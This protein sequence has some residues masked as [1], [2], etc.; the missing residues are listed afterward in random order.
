MAADTDPKNSPDLSR[1]LRFAR[2]ATSIAI[3]A[4]RLLPRILPLAAVLSLFAT[5]SWFGA[6]RAVPD[7]LR[8]GMVAAFAL[9]ALASLWPLRSLR[10]ADRRAIDRRLEQANLLAHAPITTQD[11]RPSGDSDAFAAA[12]WREHQRRMAESVSSVEEAGARTDIPARD[13]YALRAFVALL[14]VTAFAYSF[15]ISGGSLGDAFRAHNAGEVIPARIDA[16]VTPPPYTGLAPI[17][18]TS[19]QNAIKSTVTVP[20]GSLAV[21]RIAGGSGRET[22]TWPQPELPLRMAEGG[23]DASV[24]TASRRFEV[25]LEESGELAISEGTG[26][27]RSWR[28]EVTPDDPPS[29]A[30]QDDPSRAVNGTMTVEYMATDDHR[31]SAARGIIALADDQPDAAHPLYEAPELPLSLPR[32]SSDNGVAKTMADLSEHPWAGARVE[33]TLE[34]EDDRGQI[35]RSATKTLVLPGRP[36]SNP[37]AR[38]IIEQRRSLALDANSVPKI[39]DVIDVLT[40]YPEETIKDAGHFLGL[41]TARARLM[42]A[43][44]NDEALRGVVDYLWEFARTIEDGNL[45]DAERRMREAQQALQDA[46]ENGASDEQIEELMAEL[47]EAMQEYLRELARQMENNPDLAEQIPEGAAQ[48]LD[49]QSL[50]EMLDKIEELAKSGAREQAQEMLSQL[51]DMMNNL[52]MG[53]HNQQ[54]GD[55]QNRAQQQMNEL[56]EILR[57]QQELMNETYRQNRRNGESQQGEQG[58]TGEG[59]QGQEGQGGQQGQQFGQNGQRGL[60][61]LAPGQQ[62]LRERLDRFM[63]GLRG[64][65]INPGEEFG[66]AGRAMGEAGEALQ[67]GDGEGAFSDQGEAMEALRQGANSMMQQMQQAMDGGTGASE[68]GG[69]RNGIDRD[70][71]GRPQRSA[72]PD[73]GESVEVPDEIDIRRAREILEAIRRRLGNALSPQLEKEYLERLLELN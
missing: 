34:A 46:L 9:A 2:F 6:F 23:G 54:Q 31:V 4:E 1:K 55:G 50:Q 15:G 57:R 45:S 19:E 65:G 21:V 14:M 3:V 71:L 66:D 30:F 7:A 25:A 59:Q 22:V 40:L 13:P 20:E 68:P 67:E 12:L 41:V 10:T 53:R 60:Q 70:P 49:M 32:R 64:M 17:F 69:N 56:G 35:G 24:P 43:Y 33:L 36:F 62:T 28:F 39:V 58:Q 11:D 42:T 61:G 37:L 5:L 8:L 29:I 27:L 63:D 38:A 48:E 72:G 44:G 73:F 51:Q 16:W 47:R 26:P 52:Q 18:L